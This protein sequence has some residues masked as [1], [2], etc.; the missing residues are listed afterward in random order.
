M[1]HLSSHLFVAKGIKRH[2]TCVF[3][4]TELKKVPMCFVLIISM[5]QLYAILLVQ[6]LCTFD[7]RP[8]ASFLPTDLFL[9]SELAVHH[10]GSS[11]VFIFIVFIGTLYI[12]ANESN[13]LS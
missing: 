12:T 11:P 6:K 1:N 7:T 8:A 10:A 3:G 2:M 9:N 4:T 5:Y 13:V